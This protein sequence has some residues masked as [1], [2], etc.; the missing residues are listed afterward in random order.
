MV[1]HGRVAPLEVTARPA[2]QGEPLPFEAMTTGGGGEPLKVSVA[3]TA[4]N[5]AYG[6]DVAGLQR[7]QTRDWVSRA[8]EEYANAPAPSFEAYGPKTRRDMLRLLDFT[9]GVPD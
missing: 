5:G 1:D 2:P 8:R 6:V 3:L 7:A 4:L 9:R